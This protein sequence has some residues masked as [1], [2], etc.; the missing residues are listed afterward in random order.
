MLATEA[1]SN[2]Q[3]LHSAG[4]TNTCQAASANGKPQ[5]GHAQDTQTLELTCTQG[6]DRTMPTSLEVHLPRNESQLIIKTCA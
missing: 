1:G 5:T 4:E 6:W 3:G 2:V